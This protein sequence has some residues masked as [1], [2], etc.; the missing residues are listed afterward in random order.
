MGGIC[1]VRRWDGLR[2]HDMHTKFH[3]E[4]FRHSKV[5]WGGIHREHGDRIN[6]LIFFQNKESRLIT[7]GL[8]TFNYRH[9]QWLVSCVL[10]A[11]ESRW[12]R[13]TCLVRFIS[14]LILISPVDTA[15]LHKQPL[16]FMGD[17]CSVNWIRD[18][19]NYF[20]LAPPATKYYERSQG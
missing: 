13:E 5:N 4:W 2:C 8:W 14:S 15:S 17:S 10:K 9:R 6:L 7:T 16:Q 20:A 19:R 12:I 11:E 3:E 1:E 18:S